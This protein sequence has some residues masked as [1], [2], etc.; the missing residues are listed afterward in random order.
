MAKSF[1]IFLD[2]VKLKSIPCRRNIV[3]MTVLYIINKILKISSEEKPSGSTWKIGTLS[4]KK[5][6]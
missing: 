1:F 5:V 6:Q 3:T 4:L 2:L